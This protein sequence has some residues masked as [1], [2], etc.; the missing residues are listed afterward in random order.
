MILQWL[1]DFCFVTA[2]GGCLYLATAAALTLRFHGHRAPRAAKPLPVSI[3]KPLHGEGERVFHCLAS[4]CSQRYPAP[5]Q[6]VCGVEEP[7]DAAVPLV[8]RLQA[9]FPGKEIELRI[10]PRTHG[11][12]RKVSNL[13]NIAGLADHEVVILADSDIAVDPDYLARIVGGLQQPGVGAVTCL[14][15]GMPGSGAWARLST[16]TVN[17]HF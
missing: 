1:S 6:M 17:A 3:L 13:A 4:F 5:V 14:Y 15:H 2:C 7:G 8:K 12:N 16:L 9:A 10:D 11:G